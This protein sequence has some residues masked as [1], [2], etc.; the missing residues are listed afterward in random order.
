MS[1]TSLQQQLSPFERTAIPQYLQRTGLPKIQVPIALKSQESTTLS[2]NYELA[3]ELTGVMRI[4]VDS[5]YYRALITTSVTDSDTSI[6]YER[7]FV[8]LRFT[9]GNSTQGRI[10][11]EILKQVGQPRYNDLGSA[12][13]MEFPKAGIIVPL[14]LP[15]VS[16]AVM[17]FHENPLVVASFKEP[18]TFQRIK[19]EVT[20]IYDQPV[21]FTDLVILLNVY[22]MVDN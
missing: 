13:R 4:D 15:D 12:N 5:L 19:V 8:N 7:P 20:D 17:R 3:D 11:G 18:K 2:F 9:L 22:C 21:E 1:V 14:E 6:V 16:R 10:V